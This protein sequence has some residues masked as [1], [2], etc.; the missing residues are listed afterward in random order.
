[1]TQ[2]SVPSDVLHLIVSEIVVDYFEEL[3]V[4]SLA[5]TLNKVSET[6]CCSIVAHE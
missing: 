1:M 2:T 4:G 6:V 5:L 3:F